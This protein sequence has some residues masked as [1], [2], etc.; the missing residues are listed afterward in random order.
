MTPRVLG[1]AE[2]Y[3]FSLCLA[4]DEVPGSANDLVV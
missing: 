2:N 3:N 1:S 4:G